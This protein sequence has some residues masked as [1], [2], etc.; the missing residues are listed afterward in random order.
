MLP[1]IKYPYLEGGYSVGRMEKKL[2]KA[3]INI[4]KQLLDCYSAVCLDVM[5]YDKIILY[6]P[7]KPETCLASQ[8]LYLQTSQTGHQK[9]K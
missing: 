3:K 8:Q 7:S 6:C 1:F 9:N 2:L 4:D 5:S